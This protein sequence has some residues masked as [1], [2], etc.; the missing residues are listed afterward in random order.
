MHISKGRRHIE[1]TIYSIN[2]AKHYLNIIS[3]Y[4][5]KHSW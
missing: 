3:Y 5:L 4:S 1:L 2:Q